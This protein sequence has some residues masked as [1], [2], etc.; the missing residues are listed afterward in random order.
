MA[1]VGRVAM[2]APTDAFQYTLPLLGQQDAVSLVTSFA[3]ACVNNQTKSYPGA[4][5]L[6][7]AQ[8]GSG[9]L[10]LSVAV[11]H[12]GGV[13]SAEKSIDTTAA[14]EMANQG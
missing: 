2:T 3:V 8:P 13:A 9:V 6:P 7:A 11:G 4:V 10:E 12:F 14:W 1:G 5:Q